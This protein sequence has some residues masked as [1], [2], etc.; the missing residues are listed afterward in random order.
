M[1]CCF[2]AIE[3][4]N[5]DCMKVVM[6][7]IAKLFLT[8]VPNEPRKPQNFSPSNETLLLTVFD[9]WCEMIALPHVP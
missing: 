1:G 4:E 2:V 8:Y 6:D 7:K 3:L 9:V 5:C